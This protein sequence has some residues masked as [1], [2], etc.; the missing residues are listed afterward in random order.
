MINGKYAGKR[1]DTAR[2]NVIFKTTDCSR[3]L[4]SKIDWLEHKDFCFPIKK[5]TRVNLLNQG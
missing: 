4:R 2:K 5:T 3:M 1:I